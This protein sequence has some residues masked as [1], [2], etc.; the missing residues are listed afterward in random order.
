MKYFCKYPN[1]LTLKDYL[2]KK[3]KEYQDSGR[4]SELLDDELEN[5]LGFVLLKID[6]TLSSSKEKLQQNIDLL[7]KIDS[8]SK[9]EYLARVDEEEESSYS[10]EALLLVMHDPK[11]ALDVI[12]NNMKITFR[13]EKQNLYEMFL[14][15]ITINCIK[16]IVEANKVKATT[17]KV[18]F[19]DEVI[20]KSESH[21][22]SPSQG[23]VGSSMN[24]QYQSFTGGEKKGEAENS[25]THNL[26][27]KLGNN[28]KLGGSLNQSLRTITYI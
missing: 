1:K 18:A 21:L 11:G 7:L 24:Y 10:L 5:L 4:Y 25:K 8:I 17:K 12:G 13:N 3:F 28:L 16:E 22:V 6:V 20:S 23:S 9:E 2:Q 26:K 19:S 14:K 27:E 15:E